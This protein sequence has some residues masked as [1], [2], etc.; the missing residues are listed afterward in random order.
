MLLVV[1][2]L[3]GCACYLLTDVTGF[4]R[5]LGTKLVV[6]PYGTLQQVV[7]AVAILAWPLWLAAYW[8]LP[9]RDG[10]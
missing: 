3:I 1:W 4:V 7:S 10:E 5:W 9:W 2:I 6:L 8:G